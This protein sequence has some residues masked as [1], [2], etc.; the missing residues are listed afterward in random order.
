VQ[1]LI[2][3]GTGTGKSSLADALCC[4]YR[5]AGLVNTGD[6]REALRA[7]ATPTAHPELFPSADAATEGGGQTGPAVHYRQQAAVVVRAVGTVLERLAAPR[8]L[9]GAEGMH[10]LP[11]ILDYV[12][13]NT[14]HVILFRQPDKATHQS[15]LISR[16]EQEGRRPWSKY[17]EQF[18]AIRTI[19]TY[20][21]QSWQSVSSV[22]VH[23]VDSVSEGL[24]ALSSLDEQFRRDPEN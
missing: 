14:T 23:V 24:S 3:G 9:S 15:R 22:N 7:V 19:G 17:A 11:P 6:I 21:E 4:R 20:I 18:D 12:D 13:V 5:L 8:T 1:V 16:G 10:L 2:A